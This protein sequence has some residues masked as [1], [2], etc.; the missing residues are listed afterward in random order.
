D[1]HVTGVQTCA[2]PILDEQ[3]GLQLLQYSQ[4]DATFSGIEGQVRQRLSR[5]VA[6]TLFG[7]LVRARLDDSGRLPRI[8]PAR[9][10]ARLEANWRSGERR[11]GK[12]GS[13]PV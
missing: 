1:F 12:G 11:V 9:L 7:D 5:N 4:G 3:G 8:S 10:G 13:A 6:A 2:L